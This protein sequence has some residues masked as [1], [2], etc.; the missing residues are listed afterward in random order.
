MREFFR[1]WKRKLGV[2][3]LLLSCV[4]AG[5]WVRSLIEPDF[6]EIKVFDTMLVLATDD[7]C[8]EFLMQSAPVSIEADEGSSAP[9]NESES[10]TALESSPES[11]RM[12]L[13]PTPIGISVDLHLKTVFRVPLWALVVPLIALSGWLL[14]SQPR[15]AK[16]RTSPVTPP[17]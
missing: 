10:N 5:L 16:L 2:L 14:L 11:E 15:P 1:G 3:T 4:F 8:L 12:A 13:A 17:K 7:Q 9:Q 6:F